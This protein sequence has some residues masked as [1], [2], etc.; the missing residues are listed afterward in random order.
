MNAPTM[1]E[2]RI[3]ERGWLERV[4]SVLAPVRAGEGITALL[5]SANVFLLLASY[6]V[7][8]TVRESLILTEGGA[9]VKSY[10]AAAQ[11]ALL[12]LVVP[13]YGAFA[14]KVNRS[15]LITWV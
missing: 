6:Y 10:S 9:E 14:S 4:L 2:P 15:R 8:K 3:E 12:L 7:L 5:L 11:A 1:I 13:A